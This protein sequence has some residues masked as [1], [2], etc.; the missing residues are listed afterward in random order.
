V[1]EA[2]LRA[3]LTRLESRLQLQ[4]VLATTGQPVALP[5]ALSESEDSTG[6]PGGTS[7]MLDIT[8]LRLVNDLDKTRRLGGLLEQVWPFQLLSLFCCFAETGCNQSIDR[9]L[10]YR[11]D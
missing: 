8:I 6:A 7:G 5:I 10:Q 3:T 11:N 9:L 4:G 2:S 1:F